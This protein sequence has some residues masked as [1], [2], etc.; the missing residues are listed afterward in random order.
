MGGIDVGHQRDVRLS[1][2]GQAGDLAGMI[3]AELGD[4]DLI[5]RLGT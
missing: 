5:L 4:D 3:G 2:P 1:N